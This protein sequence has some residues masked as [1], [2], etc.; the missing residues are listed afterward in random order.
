MSGASGKFEPL[1]RSAVEALC[2]ELEH[3]VSVRAPEGLLRIGSAGRGELVARRGREKTVEC[4]GDLEYLHVAPTAEAGR[5]FAA[6]VAKARVGRPHLSSVAVTSLTG[7]QLRR[8][9]HTFWLWEAWRS[10]VSVSGHDFRPLLP[11]IT[12]K[13]LD[14]RELNEILLW[15][16]LKLVEVVDARLLRQHSREGCDHSC[17]EMRWGISRQLLDIPTWWLPRHGALLAGIEARTNVFTQDE[18]VPTGIRQLVAA[19]WRFRRGHGSDLSC[20]QWAMRTAS[21]LLWCDAE[22]SVPTPERRFTDGSARVLASR[23]KFFY[24]RRGIGVA[25]LL[26]QVVRSRERLHRVLLPLVASIAS[27]QFRGQTDWDDEA[28]SV[29]TRARGEIEWLVAEAA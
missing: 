24:G 8:L 25:A 15:R 21:A 12:L 26:P 3:A 13:T 5:L 27:S 6:R 10:G 4:L 20:S 1:A 7:S 17:F 2:E 18:S 28:T 11:V 23:L 29:L 22:R 9:R 16:M 14:L 19:A